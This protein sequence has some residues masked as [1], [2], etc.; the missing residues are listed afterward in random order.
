MATDTALSRHPYLTLSDLCEI[1]GLPHNYGEWVI[2]CD[3]ANGLV[4]QIVRTEKG[5]IWPFMVD[6]RLSSTKVRNY[7]YLVAPTIQWDAAPLPIAESFMS[8][9]DVAHR[10]NEMGGVVG[11]RNFDEVKEEW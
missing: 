6:L 8:K 5:S 11:I 10:L 3:M 7:G 1:T 2:E 4:A 9:L